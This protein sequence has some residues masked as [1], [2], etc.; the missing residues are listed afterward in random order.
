MPYGLTNDGL[1]VIQSAIKHDIDLN[2]IN[3]M[4]MD[5]SNKTNKWD[6]LR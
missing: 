2:S 6:K 3:I 5:Y 4:T 1:N